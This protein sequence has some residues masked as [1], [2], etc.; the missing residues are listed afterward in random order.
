MIHQDNIKR[1]RGRNKA[2]AHGNVKKNMLNGNPDAEFIT[3]L[4]L[5]E[6]KRYNVEVVAVYKVS[7]VYKIII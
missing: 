1:A 2:V 5:A 4:S 6:L 3:T 7:I